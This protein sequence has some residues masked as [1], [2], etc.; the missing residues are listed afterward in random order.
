[1]KDVDGKLSGHESE[2]QVDEGGTDCS[3]YESEIQTEN[4]ER[5]NA[6][7]DNIESFMAEAPANAKTYSDYEIN[8][9]RIVDVQ[10]FFEQL[11]SISSHNSGNCSFG[12]LEI[13]KEI[14]VGLESK[15]SMQCSSC[16]KK[17]IV[18]TNQDESTTGTMNLNSTATLAANIIGIG[19]SQLEQFT[20][21]LDVPVMS[22]GTFKKLNDEIGSFWEDTA[23]ECM[24]AAAEKE[25]I[26]AIAR[27]DVDEEDGIP[28]IK[29]VTDACWSK[30]SYNK[31]YTSLSGTASIVGADT[32]KVIWIAVKNKYCVICVRNANKNLEPPPH[33][34]TRN[35]TGP[36]SEMEWQ[37]IVE[38]FEKSVELY[39]IRY[40]ILVADGDSNTHAKLLERRPYGH[41]TIVKRGCTNHIKRNFRKH[42]ETS[43]TGCPRGLNKIVCDNFERIR[44]DVCCA[45][46]FRKNENKPESEK[47]ALLKSDLNNIVFHIVGQHTNCPQY[48]KKSC[49]RDENY[50]PALTACGTLEKILKIMRSLVYCAKDLLLGETNNV[51]EHFNSIVAMLSGAKRINFSLSNA[52]GYQANAALV[53]FNTQTALSSFYHTIFKKSPARIARKIE[54]KR[55]RKTQQGKERRR[56]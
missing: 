47:I 17:F 18:R 37:S 36:S 46:E 23:E 55:L 30:R 56:R 41:R 15:L 7:N 1:M 25:R 44:R 10:Y 33:F 16:N 32:G 45:V 3:G 24:R 27:G 35:F 31:N 43:A 42:L 12:N 13:R 21:V 5:H 52:Y 14:R 50:V 19:F 38:G 54:L 39:G 28:F 11:K 29:V 51:A 4:I 26:A 22:S 53:Q 40:L 9:R 8:G 34:C 20:S 49:I 48:I 2:I 6:C